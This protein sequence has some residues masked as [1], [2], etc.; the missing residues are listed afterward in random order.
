MLGM[1][2][3]ASTRRFSAL[4]RNAGASHQ[5]F[6]VSDY[7]LASRCTWCGLAIFAPLLARIGIA[8]FQPDVASPSWACWRYGTHRDVDRSIG[9]G[10]QGR[11]HWRTTAVLITLAHE[12]IC[13]PRS[14][15]RHSARWIVLATRTGQGAREFLAR[16]ISGIGRR[17][18]HPRG[19]CDLRAYFDAGLRPS[20]SCFDGSATA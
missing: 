4:F 19:P 10:K 12:Q 18:S 9:T 6:G 11:R 17:A 8:Q 1:S 20:R 15:K 2:A 16:V 7:P 13:A 5:G 3:S 14:S